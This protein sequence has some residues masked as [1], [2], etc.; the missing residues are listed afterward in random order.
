MGPDGKGEEGDV[1]LFVLGEA[2]VGASRSVIAWK[3][4][5]QLYFACCLGL[6]LRPSPGNFGHP[7]VV[8]RPHACTG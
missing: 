5:R 6:S 1:M 3:R 4:W 2:R 7:P 8:I